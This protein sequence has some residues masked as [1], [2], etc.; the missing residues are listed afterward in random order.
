MRPNKRV[1]N[2]ISL[3]VVLG[4]GLIW[5]SSFFLNQEKEVVE[6]PVKFG[7]FSSPFIDV[8]I[9]S[10]KY[11]LH[12]DLGFDC[13]L[14]LNKSILDSIQKTEYEMWPHIDF[15]GRKYTSPSFFI[16]KVKIG[17]ILFYGIVAKERNLEFCENTSISVK[18]IGK[19]P[20]GL[21]KT[22]GSIGLNL[23]NRANLLLDFPSSRICITNHLK[24]LKKAHELFKKWIKAPFTIDRGILVIIETDLGPKRF[25]LD[26][27][28]TVTWIRSSSLS[29]D[30]LKVGDLGLPFFPNSKFVIGDHDFGAWNLYSLDIAPELDFIDGF[31]GMDFL[32]NHSTYIDFSKHLLSISGG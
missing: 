11:P 3:L 20:P 6:L 2:L 14:S 29:K 25:M 31:L 19:N 16:E 28:S 15:R 24:R 21:S 22:T 18:I 26:T 12:L 7:K 8:E 5:S 1:R 9:E 32:K 30:Q 4:M 23:L 27:G 17:G 13:Q 10:K